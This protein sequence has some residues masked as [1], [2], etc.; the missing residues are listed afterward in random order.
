MAGKPPAAFSCLPSGAIA[1]KQHPTLCFFTAHLHTSTDPTAPSCTL[2]LLCLYLFSLM[3]SL[4]LFLSHSVCLY[5]D[6][7][8]GR[9]S[10][11]CK[12][13]WEAGLAEDSDKGKTKG[14]GEWHKRSFIND[15][16][17]F[18]CGS[19]TCLSWWKAEPIR[20]WHTFIESQYPMAAIF[21]T[22]PVAYRGW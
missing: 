14:L 20:A 11:V 5:V 1:N 3:W 8:T 16:Y 17:L 18:Y 10:A 22:S 13:S 12:H 7:S 4:S 19:N 9:D 15:P 21:Q 2:A 6:N